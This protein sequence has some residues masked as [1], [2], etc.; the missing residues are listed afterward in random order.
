MSPTAQSSHAKHT[1]ASKA[2]L[3][4]SFSFST[5]ASR[6]VFKRDTS[7]FVLVVERGV[8]RSSRNDAA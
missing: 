1:L 2:S 4:K 3:G 6:D 8:E 7:A 5:A